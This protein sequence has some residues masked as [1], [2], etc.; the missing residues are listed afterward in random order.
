MYKTLTPK[1]VKEIITQEKPA[2]ITIH[3]QLTKITQQDIKNLKLNESIVCR[4]D[5]GYLT[6]EIIK[7]NSNFYQIIKY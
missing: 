2:E 3:T 5:D 7:I 4:D 1:E 6:L